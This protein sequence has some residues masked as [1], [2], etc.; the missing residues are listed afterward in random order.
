MSV[1]PNT[2][3]RSSCVNR[4]V[5]CCEG[6]AAGKEFAEERLADAE[7]AR[8]LVAKGEPFGDVVVGVGLFGRLALGDFGEFGRRDEGAF[9]GDGVECQVL[10][11]GREPC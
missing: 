10:I 6:W 9:E 11:C 8:G 2:S 7:V 4:I 5:A 1:N 3:R